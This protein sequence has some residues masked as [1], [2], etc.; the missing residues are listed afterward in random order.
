MLAIIVPLYTLAKWLL[1]A[2]KKCVLITFSMSAIID[3]TDKEWCRFHVGETF[4]THS[5]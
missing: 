5:F 2:G 1:S 3:L 4:K